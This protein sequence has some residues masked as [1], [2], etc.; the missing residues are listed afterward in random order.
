[1]RKLCILIG[2]SLALSAPP[3]QAVVTVTLQDGPGN[4]GGGEF[5]ATL[6]PALMPTFVTFCLE[7][8][9]F[10]NFNKP[11]NVVFNDG[12]V[13]GGTDS[14]GDSSN[15]KDIIKKGTAYLYS[16]M[17]AGTLPGYNYGVGRVSSAN[18]L[19]HAIWYFEGEE[20]FAEANP[21]PTPNQYLLDSFWN[22]AGFGNLNNAKAL[23]SPGGYGVQVMNLT[24]PTT[25]VMRQD[26][27]APMVPEPSTYLAGALLLIPL[28]A[29]V[30]RLRRTA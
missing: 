28:L 7:K 30:R 22:T 9:E 10:I 29:Q 8:T 11:F 13:L 16:K 26:Q 19:Q 12:A 18:E 24:S 21:N 25:A 14:D 4:T 27:L 20:T 15:G 2:L 6:N 5:Y 1:M 23:N 3:L 17:L